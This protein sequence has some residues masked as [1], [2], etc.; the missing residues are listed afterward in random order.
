MPTLGIFVPAEKTSGVLDALK[1]ANPETDV[2]G[3]TN[4]E[5]AELL[6]KVTV[7]KIHRNHIYQTL[8]AELSAANALAMAQAEQ[9]SE[10][11]I[12]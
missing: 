1:W 5:A 6:L 9:E 4:Q 10:L 3:L 2:T 7:R 11:D 8:A 12:S